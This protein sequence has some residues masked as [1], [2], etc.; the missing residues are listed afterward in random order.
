[1]SMAM[2]YCVYAG[3]RGV[4]LPVVE[5]KKIKNAIFRN[6]YHKKIHILEKTALLII[7]FLLESHFRKFSLEKKYL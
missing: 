1:M 7:T 2:I 6:A 5:K 4:I 3:V